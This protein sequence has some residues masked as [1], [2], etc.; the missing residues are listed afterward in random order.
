LPVQNVIPFSDK[1]SV[2]SF[3]KPKIIPKMNNTFRNI[4]FAAS[5]I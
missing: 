4:H 3:A 5:Q 1:N 2:F